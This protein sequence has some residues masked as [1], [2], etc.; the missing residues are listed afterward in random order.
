MR[1]QG[2][3]CLQKFDRQQS[4]N[5]AYRYTS[6]DLTTIPPSVLY[7]RLRRARLVNT[8]LVLPPP[9]YYAILSESL[10]PSTVHRT[11]GDIPHHP[12]HAHRITS[13]SPPTRS[14]SP[15]FTVGA[16]LLDTCP[17][18]QYLRRTSTPNLRNFPPSL[19]LLTS[20][21]QKKLTSITDLPTS[22]RTETPKSR[23]PAR[24]TAP[25]PSYPVHHRNHGT[26]L[27]PLC[28]TAPPPLQAPS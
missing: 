19:H 22:R 11:A 14:P 18:P 8:K 13:R 15:R 10:P 24:S 5:M 26:E 16:C 3:R 17:Y 6:N 21:P 9:K 4:R 28:Q 23:N 1:R 2:S 20:K 27:S 7:F 12:Q 25:S